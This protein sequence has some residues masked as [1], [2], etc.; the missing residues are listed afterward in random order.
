MLV[1]TI[2]KTIQLIGVTDRRSHEAC[3]LA[4]REVIPG[5]RGGHGEA[6]HALV[7]LQKDDARVVDHVQDFLQIP[8]CSRPRV[9]M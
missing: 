3:P 9:F 4:R 1:L 5:V 7:R 8:R 2:A 6:V